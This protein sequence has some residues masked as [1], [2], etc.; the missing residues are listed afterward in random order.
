[1]NIW[2]MVQPINQISLGPKRVGPIIQDLK[3]VLK[4]TTFLL[5]LEASR[6]EFH[7]TPYVLSYPLGF[8]SEIGSLLVGVVEMPSSI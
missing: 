6:D 5:T 2:F 7:F 4:G 1:M 3:S 8:T